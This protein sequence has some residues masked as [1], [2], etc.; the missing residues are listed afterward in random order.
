MIAEAMPCPNKAE[1]KGLVGITKAKSS[2]QSMEVP[3]QD[4][5]LE[6]SEGQE[7]RL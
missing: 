4:K 6:G 3:R 2:N 7:K 5:I 1:E